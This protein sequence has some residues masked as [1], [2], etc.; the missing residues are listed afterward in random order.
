MNGVGMTTDFPPE[1][2]I[3][4]NPPKRQTFT[5]S[6]TGILSTCPL[7]VNINAPS[8]IVICVSVPGRYQSK[9]PDRCGY[10]MTA[11]A[12]PAMTMNSVAATNTGQ[13]GGNPA[14][15]PISAPTTTAPT[16]TPNTLSELLRDLKVP[17]RNWTAAAR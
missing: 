8:T 10:V 14:T 5:T 7:S 16:T 2:W 15:I 3:A 1:P 12:P 11:E 6:V 9:V 13:Y 17:T 4:D